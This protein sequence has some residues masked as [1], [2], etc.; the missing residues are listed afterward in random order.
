MYIE[1][2]VFFKNNR[3]G[4]L[5]YYLQMKTY[6]VNLKAVHVHNVSITERNP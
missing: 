3:K 6:V 1:F 4:D 2:D 5:Y